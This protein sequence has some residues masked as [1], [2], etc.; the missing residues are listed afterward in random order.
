GGHMGTRAQLARI[1]LAIA[2]SWALVS[3]FW[4]RLASAYAWMIRHDYTACAQCHADPSGGGLL[5]AYG[6]AQGELILRTHY[7][8]PPEDPGGISGFLFGAV[9][10][11]DDVLLGGDVRGVALRQKANGSPALS[12]AF[13]MQ[14]DAT[15]QVSVD[16]FRANASLGF[17]QKG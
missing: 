12:D 6:R 17:A 1:R 3:V 8:P 16:R 5:T 9:P 14:A 15:G 10:L 4:P 13:L 2:L 7:G 11:P